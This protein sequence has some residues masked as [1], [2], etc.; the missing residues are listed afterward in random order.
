MGIPPVLSGAR[1]PFED[2][3]AAAGPRSS[4]SSPTTG[5]VGAALSV[6]VES[7][8]PAGVSEPVLS[9]SVPTSRGERP[10]CGSF[11]SFVSSRHPP[12]SPLV[13]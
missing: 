2:L 7:A 5:E 11:S 9:V 8:D 12:E 1:S 10:S 6:S 13:S 3:W 4:A